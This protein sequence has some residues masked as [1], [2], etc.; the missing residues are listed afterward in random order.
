VFKPIAALNQFILNIASPQTIIE[1]TP[2]DAAVYSIHFYRHSLSSLS[3]KHYFFQVLCLR[4]NLGI[5][6]GA[7]AARAADGIPKLLL[8]IIR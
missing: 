4:F 6:A 5:W 3:L 7:R 1:K 2:S 8:A